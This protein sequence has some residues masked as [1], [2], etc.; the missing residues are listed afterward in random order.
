MPEV[1]PVKLKT[2]LL[3][4]VLTETTA[5]TLPSEIVSVLATALVNE[6]VP[7]TLYWLVVDKHSVGVTAKAS[8]G[9]AGATMQEAGAV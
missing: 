1:S 9:T 4:P 2:A 5:L 8:A 3:C 7:L 6:S